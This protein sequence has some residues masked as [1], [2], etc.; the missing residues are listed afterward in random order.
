[1]L[2]QI[3][4]HTFSSGIYTMP[5]PSCLHLHIYIA[6]SPPPTVLQRSCQLICWPSS[7]AALMA[8]QR[9]AAEKNYYKNVV[10]C[11]VCVCVW[12][13]CAVPFS[14]STNTLIHTHKLHIYCSSWYYGKCLPVKSANEISN[15]RVLTKRRVLWVRGLRESTVPGSSVYIV[16]WMWSSNP[17]PFGHIGHFTCL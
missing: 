6:L 5:L 13:R 2:R 3:V 15:I 9:M 10:L 1:M 12:K 11:V 17:S 14:N 4:L 8:G 7:E 16:L